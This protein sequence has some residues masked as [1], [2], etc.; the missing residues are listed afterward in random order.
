MTIIAMG[1]K[2]KEENEKVAILLNLMLAKA[3][4]ANRD[5]VEACIAIVENG[6]GSL[7]KGSLALKL[8]ERVCQTAGNEA[9]YNATVAH[10][11]K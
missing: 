9:Q 5:A 8:W 1:V 3:T 6:G 7:E 10:L 11:Q 4:D 2:S